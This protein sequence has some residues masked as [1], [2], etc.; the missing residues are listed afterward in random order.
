MEIKRKLYLTRV[1][2]LFLL[3]DTMEKN[4]FL[5]NLQK[6]AESMLIEMQVFSLF[7]YAS[8]EK[9]DDDKAT[10][11]RD[12]ENL[13]NNTF[14]LTPMSNQNDP[15]E[16]KQDTNYNRMTEEI[17]SKN[18]L[19]HINRQQYDKVAK[20]T[21]I[22]IFSRLDELRIKTS[23]KCFC[24]DVDNLLLWAHYANAHA[25]YC[26]EYNSIQ[27]FELWQC[28]LMPVVYQEQYPSAHFSINE[29][30]VYMSNLRC[31]ATK[32]TH[33]DY[34]NEWRIIRCCNTKEEHVGVAPKPN[35][36]YLGV[37]AKEFYKK[38]MLEFCTKNKI[39][40]YQMNCAKSAYQLEK[41]MI[42]KGET[43]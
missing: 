5:G 22:D 23:I 38:E 4:E 32:S 36:I 33:W 27:L 12:K 20:P 3:E 25:G 6:L 35:A 24:E 30:E 39:D 18:P 15:F 14:Y 31:F 28:S 43:I 17:L 1:L 41:K 9:H 19:M 7:R 34:E 40:L 26:I 11:L 16:F 8:F 21:H 29:K 37:N 42:Y 10:W 13:E 2:E